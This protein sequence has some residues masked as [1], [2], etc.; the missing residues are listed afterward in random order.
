[1]NFSKAAGFTLKTSLVTLILMV[2]MIA[3]STAVVP[4]DEQQIEAAGNSMLP[5]LIVCAV[6]ALIISLIIT[7]TSWRG[8]PL[9]LGLTI[10]FYGVQTFMGQIEAV[11]F[12]TPLGE[13]MGAGSVPELTMPLD[14]IFGQF[15]VG[16]ALAAIGVPAAAAL[17]GKAKQGE[18]PE[19]DKKQGKFTAGEWILKLIAIMVLYILLYFG[20]GYYVAWKSPALTAFYQG[21]DPGSFL[22]QMKHVATQTP[23]LIPLQA[24][25]ALLWTAFSL[26]VVK[27]L[28]SAPWK[29]A[30]LMGLFLSLPMNIPHIVPNAYMPP[31]VRMAHFIETASSNFIFGMLIF[32][33]FHRHHRSLKDVLGLNRQGADRARQT[34]EA[35][36][37]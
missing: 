15:I 14:F 19:Q 35:V 21:T 17:F 24:F 31:A 7:Q 2:V 22:A 11:V 5:L 33:L 25:R 3:V 27:M 26:P 23:T 37:G 6:N 32:W 30:L 1:M 9:M 10:A 13:T 12:L 20:F 29:G 8:F 28:R 16:A 4:M 36:S 18:Q 34:A